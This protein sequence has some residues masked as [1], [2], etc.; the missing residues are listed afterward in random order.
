MGVNTALYKSLT[1]GVSAA[2]TGVAGG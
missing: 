1:F 2:Y